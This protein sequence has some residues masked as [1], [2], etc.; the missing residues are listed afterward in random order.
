MSWLGRTRTAPVAVGESL[1][2]DLVDFVS[3]HQPRL[4]RLAALVCHNVADAEDAVQAG[5][6]QAWRRR[7]TLRDPTKLAAWL[8]RIIVREAIR[9]DR[10]DS[11]F[12]ARWLP[13][14]REIVV[15]ATDLSDEVGSSV[16][17][18]DALRVAFE[19]LPAAQRAVVALH[20]YAGYSMPETAEI[21]G[22]SL[23]TARS[24][25]RLARK[26]LRAQL[27]EDVA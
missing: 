20:L 9:H 17:G 24:R 5:L 10:R 14:P 25:L 19:A 3:Q 16:T 15:D 7:H 11:S 21:V 4:V 2:R 26:R 18:R 12:L 27:E 13:G 8:D 23:E 1:D 22:V 6:E